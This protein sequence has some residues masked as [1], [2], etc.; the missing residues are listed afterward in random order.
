MRIIIEIKKNRCNRIGER[1]GYWE[2]Y[3]KNG[4]LEF[5]G[6]Y[7]NDKKDGI[8]EWYYKDGQLS[9]KDLYNLRH[10]SPNQER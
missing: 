3:Y 2:E 10:L 8:W 7:K 9:F 4:N 5:K 6:L 1:N